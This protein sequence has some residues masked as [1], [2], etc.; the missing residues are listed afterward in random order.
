[1]NNSR[2]EEKQQKLSNFVATIT[3]KLFAFPF[4]TNFIKNTGIQHLKKSKQKGILES[5]KDFSI[6]DFNSL[7][8][9]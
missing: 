3:L 9:L 8:T 2:F 1:M 4:L 6:N 7:A 5:P